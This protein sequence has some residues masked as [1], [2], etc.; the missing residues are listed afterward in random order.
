MIDSP[1]ARPMVERIE[2][3]RPPYLDV[4]RCAR[5][6]NALGRTYLTVGSWVVVRCH[7]SVKK[8]DGKRETCG[9]ENTVR[10]TR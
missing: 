2:P 10:P 1:N 4:L 7:H 3:E 5:C 8:P 9:Y 6:G